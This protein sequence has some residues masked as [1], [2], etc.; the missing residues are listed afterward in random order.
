MKLK[1]FSAKVL[2]L[3]YLENPPE[4]KKNITGRKL[5]WPNRHKG[6]EWG[7]AHPWAS[8]AGGSGPGRGQRTVSVAVLVRSK[9][10]PWP[11]WFVVAS[12]V[13]GRHGLEGMGEGTAPASRGRRRHGGAACGG[14]GTSLE[15]GR[16]CSS[17]CRLTRGY[18]GA[19]AG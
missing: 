17:S 15:A 4:L 18:R 8:W 11:P 16:R 2:S 7:A 14:A 5:N 1:V 19:A 6:M 12:K 3:G 9:Q 10:G 13:D